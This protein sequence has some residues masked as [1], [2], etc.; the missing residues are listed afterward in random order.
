MPGLMT[1][2]SAKKLSETS[3]TGNYTADENNDDL[4]LKDNDS[5]MSNY[6]RWIFDDTSYGQ[7]VCLLLKSAFGNK[8]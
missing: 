3:T 2:L 5:S 6:P 1:P 4:N 8:H 7:L